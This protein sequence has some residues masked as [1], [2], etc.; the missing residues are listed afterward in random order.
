VAAKKIVQDFAK[1][2]STEATEEYQET[3]AKI[4]KDLYDELDDLNDNEEDASDEIEDSNKKIEEAQEDKKEAQETI[5]ENKEEKEKLEQK[6]DVLNKKIKD[7]QKVLDG[8]NQEKKENDK[9]PDGN[10]IVL[11]STARLTESNVRRVLRFCFDTLE[12]D[13]ARNMAELSL[14]NGICFLCERVEYVA[15]LKPEEEI[16][17]ILAT[18]EVALSQE[19]GEVTVAAA[20]IFGALMQSCYELGIAL[21]LVINQSLRMVASWCRRQIDDD[22]RT[23]GAREM[24]HLF[25]GLAVLLRFHPEQAI[26]P[27]S[28]TGLL[29]LRYVKR[30][31]EK[32]SSNNRHATHSYLI[33]HL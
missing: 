7:Q 6:Q 15:Y 25:R 8:A 5:E 19:E 17:N 13:E 4:L 24:G 9:K 14:M 29:F 28:K 23:G 26:K 22:T 21:H 16:M 18:V 27:L 32:S 33:G 12:D 2:M 11:E 20:R 1:R 31:Y 30:F 3:Q 10:R